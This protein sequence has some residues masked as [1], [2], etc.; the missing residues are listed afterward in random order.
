MCS[1]SLDLSSLFGCDSYFPS[2]R[3][4]LLVFVSRPLLSPLILCE[5]T[6]SGNFFLRPL[7]SLGESSLHSLPSLLSLSSSSLFSR[8]LYSS[9]PVS[10]PSP[11]TFYLFPPPSPHPRP[12]LFLQF[13]FISF[14][15]LPP[16]S[17]S[18]SFSQEEILS[19][20]CYHHAE[21]RDRVLS[22]VVDE[23]L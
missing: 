16:S 11:L 6:I 13:L 14:L 2:P 22:F 12:S 17:L 20:R 8:L 21:P 1:P 19:R 3:S 18:Q 10:I 5:V 7:S 23:L 15:F 9:T 4:S